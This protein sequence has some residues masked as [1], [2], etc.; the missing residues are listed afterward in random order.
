MSATNAVLKYLQDQNRPYSA[1]DIV[2]NL[3]KEF[4]KA[5]VQKALD[6]LAESKKILEKTYG[7]QKVYCIIQEESTGNL[8]EEL[9]QI[10]SRLVE[11]SDSLRKVEVE[12][13]ASEALLK[14]LESQPTTDKAEKEVQEREEKVNSYKE[15]L[16][17]LRLSRVKV[18]KEDVEKVEKE[19]DKA[20]KEYRKRKRICMEIVDSILEGYPKSKKNLLEEV[21]IETDEEVGF[22]PPVN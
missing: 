3:H 4:G 8:A 9:Q 14:E 10:E 2:L 7:K 16:D 21:G 22:K 11:A 5:A 6:H 20:L 19:R 17:Q 13:K 1:N 12:L 18:S 15:R